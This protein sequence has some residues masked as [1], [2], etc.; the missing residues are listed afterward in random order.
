MGF[1]FGAPGAVSERS[2][3]LAFRAFLVAL[4][5]RTFAGLSGSG[6]FLFIFPLRGGAFCSYFLFGGS[7]RLPGKANLL[8]ED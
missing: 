6:A 4:S 8:L 7:R 2:W 3:A 5:G 1:L